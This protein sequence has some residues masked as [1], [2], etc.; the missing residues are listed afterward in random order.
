M[1]MGGEFLD[2]KLSLSKGLERL[3]EIDIRIFVFQLRCP[4]SVDRL[5]RRY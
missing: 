1:G 5:D 4:L 2:S 3:W